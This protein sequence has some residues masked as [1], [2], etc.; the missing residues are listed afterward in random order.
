MSNDITY[1]GTRIIKCK[2]RSHKGPFFSYTAS[3]RVITETGTMFLSIRES[4][5]DR[6]K[7]SINDE[8]N[9]GAVTVDGILF[10]NK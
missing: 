7:T 8:L 3:L 6:I 2:E 5:L 9:R 4:S 1:K 10:R